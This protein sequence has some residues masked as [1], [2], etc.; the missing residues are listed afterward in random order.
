MAFS[1]TYDTTNPG[2]AVSNREDLTDILTILEPEETPALS[3]APKSK[4][5]A[6][7]TEWTV[8]KLADP[9]SDGI[10]E[11]SDV[12]SFTDKFSGRARLGNYTQKFRRDYMV[13][14]FQQAVESVGPARIAEAEAKAM[15]EIKRDI[16]FTILSDNDRSVEDGAG[17][18]YKL[19]GLG[20]WLDS[21]GPSDVPADYRT[22]AGSIKADSSTLT[23]S[24]FDDL[25]KSIFTV[26]GD[27]NSLT[28]IAGTAVRSAITEFSRAEGASNTKVYNI[29]QDATTKQ[30]TLS[31]DTF[32]SAYGMVS[33]INGNPTCM[34]STERAYLINPEYY[35]IAELIPMGSRRL[36][37]QG[38]G[39]RGY[40]D[41]SLTLL[42]KHPGAHGKITDV[43]A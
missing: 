18:P 15:R 30:I 12:D 17:T 42:M 21:S 8:D 20:D 16:E 29:N 7:F 14:D 3:L 26:N 35:G 41:C 5:S 19:R 2:A 23:E 22:P 33:I 37:D 4:A 31:I 13:S 1:P 9:V 10:S 43:T 36:E 38:G 27:T 24:E 32:D 40:V 39:P 6:T 34:P 25:I 28:C 11:G